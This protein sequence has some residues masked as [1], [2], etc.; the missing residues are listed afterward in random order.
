LLFSKYNFG[1]ILFCIFKILFESIL[2][3]GKSHACEMPEVVSTGEINERA[4]VF[5][6]PINVAWVEN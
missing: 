1:S 3:I 6:Y 4:A 5:N 2:P